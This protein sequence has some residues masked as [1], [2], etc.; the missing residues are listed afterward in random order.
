MWSTPCSRATSIVRSVE[1]SSMISHS[2]VSKPSISFGRSR[3]VI[4]RV[5]SSLRQGIWMMSFIARIRRYRVDTLAPAMARADRFAKAAFA[6]LCIGS[7]VGFFVYPT[8]PNYDSYYS[9]LWGREVLDLQAPTFEGFR[10]PTEH[11]LAIVAGAALSLLG[12]LGDRVWV[13]LIIASYLWL[14]AG[15]YRL[16][17]TAFTPLV[18][19]I[20]AAL[21]LTRFDYAFLTAR[22]YIDIPYM[23]MVVWAA[24][25]EARRPRS[26]APVLVL[27]A[28]AGLLRPE[29]WVLAALYWCWV[30]WPASWRQRALYALLAPAGPLLWAATDYAVPGDP[31]FSLHPTSSSAEEPRRHLPLS[32]PP[33]AMPPRLSIL[34]KLAVLVAAVLGLAIALLAVP[35][36][37]AAPLALLTAGI[38]TFVLIGI[39]GA[40]AIERYLAVA[41][42]ALLVFAGVALGGFTMLEASAVRRWWGGA[43]AAAV[44]FGIVFTALHLNLNRFDA[45]LSFR[46]DA[47]DD[48]VRVLGDPRVKAGLRCGPLTLPNHKLVPDSRWIAD[49]PDDRVIARADPKAKQLGSGVGI[50][51]TSRFALFK[52]AFTSPTDS[53]LI[54]VPP[55]GFRRSTVGRFYTAYVKC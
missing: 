41:A 4:G 40:S 24:A 35:R 1:P 13:A 48:L 28:L 54:Q 47:H 27:L 9:L 8:Y 10:V 16:G 3:S 33:S 43:A 6:L 38:V 5:S 34:V 2:T 36:R 15:V 52:Q 51:V 29:A 25:L 44:L 18:G 21:L 23:A 19:A 12:D 49:L 30:A 50:Y 32:P 45:E 55:R 14:I 22:G 42:V 53:V 26:G 46:G 39:A 37:A 7:L 31:L 17:R 20:A 11:P